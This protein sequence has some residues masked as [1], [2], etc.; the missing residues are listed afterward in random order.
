MAKVG[1]QIVR[2]HG[3]KVPLGTSLEEA[4]YLLNPPNNSPPFFLLF[5]CQFQY[6]V[7]LETRHCPPSFRA[8]ISQRRVNS[9]V[10]CARIVPS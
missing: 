10:S 9:G 7:K 2:A 6:S 3:M 4:L 8:I 5:V 1:Y